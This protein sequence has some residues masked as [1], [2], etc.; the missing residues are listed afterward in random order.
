MPSGGSG[1][2]PA[3][4]AVSSKCACVLL[5]RT[6]KIIVWPQWKVTSDSAV[7]PEGL[8][9]ENPQQPYL[10]CSEQQHHISPHPGPHHLSLL[11][12][13][14]LLLSP[15]WNQMASLSSCLGLAGGSL[16]APTFT[17]MRPELLLKKTKPCAASGRSMESAARITGNTDIKLTNISTQTCMY[18]DCSRP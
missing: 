4:E 2:R 15:T 13:E 10:G 14:V 3:G 7:A 17:R 18:C 11:L 16:T 9:G 12:Q 6:P 1:S 8:S 5:G